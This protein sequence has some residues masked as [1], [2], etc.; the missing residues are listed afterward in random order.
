MKSDIHPKYYDNAKV[1]CACGA[2][3]AV[4]S[5]KESIHT[6]L[7]SKCHPFYTGI[8]KFVDTANRVA[9]YAANLKKTEELKSKK[10]GV[11]KKAKNL[12]EHEKKESLKEKKAE[13]KPKA[14]KTVAP[15]EEKKEEVK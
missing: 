2:T 13:K 5:T 8:E 3:F 11:G 6:E 1:T 14:E 10:V 9:K 15:V 4:G 12:A 7:C